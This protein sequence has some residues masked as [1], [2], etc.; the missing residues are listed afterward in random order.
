MGVAVR[1]VKETREIPGACFEAGDATV[2]GDVVEEF[3]H[4]GSIAC[5]H[6]GRQPLRPMKNATRPPLVKL[7]TKS[8]ALINSCRFL[9]FLM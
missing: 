6:D 5:A 8:G 3:V 1:D 7:F 9:I 4:V 2:G